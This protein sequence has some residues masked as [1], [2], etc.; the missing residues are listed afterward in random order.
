MEKI[1]AV[2]YATIIRDKRRSTLN[3]SEASEF[4]EPSRNS[5]TQVFQFGKHHVFSVVCLT[6]FPTVVYTD[7]WVSR[8]AVHR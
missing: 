1:P 8:D 4:F 3:K 5:K 6:D 2:E 7:M